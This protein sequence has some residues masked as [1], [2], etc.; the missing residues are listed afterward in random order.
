MQE[1]RVKNS[2]AVT[3]ARLDGEKLTAWLNSVPHGDYRQILAAILEAC[4]VPVT[5]LDNWRKGK[6]RIPELHKTKINEIAK[7]NIF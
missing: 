3:Q 4:M 2:T 6:C 5:T 1:N 7:R